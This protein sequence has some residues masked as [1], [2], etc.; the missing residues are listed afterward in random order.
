MKRVNV[1]FLALAIVAFGSIGFRARSQEVTPADVVLEQVVSGLLSPVYVTGARDGTN[2][3][4]IVEQPGRIQVL[5]PDSNTP[6]VFL[7]ISTKVFFQGERGLL[8]LAFHPQ[9]RT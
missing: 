7:T 5:Q 8:G 6:T 4:F 1:L 9:F 2:R 3:L